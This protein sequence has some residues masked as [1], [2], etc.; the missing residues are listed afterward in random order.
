MSKDELD[1]KNTTLSIQMFDI[2]QKIFISTSHLFQVLQ[3]SRIGGKDTKDCVHKV[4]DRYVSQ[5]RSF[6]S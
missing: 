5:H 4:L 2:S 6:F 1:Y 3:L